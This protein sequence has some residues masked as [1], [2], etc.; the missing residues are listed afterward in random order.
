MTGTPLTELGAI[1]AQQQYGRA[2]VALLATIPR[3][4]WRIFRMTGA[5][6]AAGQ[7]ATTRRGMRGAQAHPPCRSSCR[8]DGAILLGEC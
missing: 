4:V 5:K 7:P 3:R 6:P 1:D 8:C 2:P